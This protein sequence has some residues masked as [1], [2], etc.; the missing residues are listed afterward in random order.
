[1]LLSESLNRAPL[2]AKG[3]GLWLGPLVFFIMLI[4]APY[5]QL[6]AIDA[7]LVAAVGLFMA[8][9]WATEA[10]PIAATALLPIVFFSMLD[11]QPLKETTSAY[12]HPIIYLFLGAFILSLAIEKCG[13]HKRVALNILG[14]TGT[15][16]K[17]L[18][19]GFMIT[20]AFLSMWM[21]NTSTTMMLL[22]IATSIAAIVTRDAEAGQQE[23]FKKALLLSIAFAA[24]I[25]GMATLIGT[26]PNA[27]LAAY[28][29][30]TY[31][32]SINFLSWMLVGVP[33]A[34]ILLPI[35]WWVLT[36]SA[37]KIDLPESEE[38]VALL[39]KSKDDLGAITSAQKRVA[40]IFVAVVLFWILRRPLSSLLGIEFISDTQIALIGAL[41]LFVVP[42]K[43]GSSTALIEWS[44]LKNLPWGVLILF[45]GGLSLAAAVNSSGLASAIGSSLSDVHHAGFLLLLILATAMVI[46]LTEITSN[47]A[48]TATFLPVIAA[49]CAAANIA[50]LALLIP[51]TLAASCAF[52]LPV[53][54]APNAIVFSSGFLSVADMA[55]AGFKLNI[56]SLVILSAIGWLLVPLVFTG[57]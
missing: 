52:M 32:Q 16:G 8:I 34:L 9:W 46:F 18:I 31:G 15:Q 11:V 20:A 33:A 45:G 7:W 13:L 35:T 4:S 51:I 23:D 38:G 25:G 30:D 1:M 3:V 56:I 50:P 5:Q 29:N 26:P 14:R 57:G 55:R 41:A 19:A 36:H 47:M 43:P 28:V 21:T 6:I 27:I 48:T 17:R 42:A 2:G 54:T 22:P 24:S 39:K 10:I 40:F 12:A 49:I 37:Y 44:D 53:A